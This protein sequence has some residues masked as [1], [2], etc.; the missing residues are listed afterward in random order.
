MGYT[1]AGMKA[2]DKYVKANYDRIEIKARKGGK[3]ALKELA[4][5]AGQSMAEYVCDAV[6]EKAGAKVISSRIEDEP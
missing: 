1:K 3:A 6:N 4:A 2:V 5:A